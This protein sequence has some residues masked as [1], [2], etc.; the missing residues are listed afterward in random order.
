V[1]RDASP[2]V[3][4]LLATAI[5][6]ALALTA[7]CATSGVVRGSSLAGGRVI[8]DVAT[9][10]TRSPGEVIDDLRSVRHVYVSEVHDSATDHGVQAEVVR[11]LHDA[12]AHVVI[13][14]EWLPADAQPA[15]DAWTAGRMDEATL[16]QQARWQQVW[17][18]D[19]EGY[20]PIF[21]FARAA[22]I[23]I[24]GLNPPKGLAEAVARGGKESVP[25]AL[26]PHLPPLDTGSDAHRQ[27]FF[28]LFLAQGAAHGK[29]HGHG[30]GHPLDP[31]RLE[32]YYQAQLVRD[33]TM[34]NGVERLLA[35][36]PDA[37]VVV[38]AGIGHI[39]HAF[40]VPSRAERAAGPFR[41]V[42]PVDPGAMQD[43]AGAFLK[44]AY[45]E[46]RADWA[47]EAARLGG[48]LAVRDGP[49]R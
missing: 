16:L 46:K 41:I 33:E 26:A 48:T 4:P 29:A 6:V 42:L 19:F 22:G 31:V 40:G 1:N 18:H 15:L 30:H 43:A 25:P 44:T 45:P 36:V 23:R 13:G 8:V 9:G 14:V 47:W 38:F 7:G 24:V 10:E 32:R 39:D 21:E 3:R 20:R 2:R 5:Y 28:D 11:V 35:E 34:A 49:L 27:Y 37:V 17:G 12:G